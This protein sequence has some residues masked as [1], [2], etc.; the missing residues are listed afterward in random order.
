MRNRNLWCAL[1]FFALTV[2]LTA[3][4]PDRTRAEQLLDRATAHIDEGEYDAAIAPAQEAAKLFS[5]LG[6]TNN[7]TAALNEA[8]LAQ[9]YAGDYPAARSSFD[10][11]LRVATSSNNAEGI[12]EEH[13]NLSS[14]DFYTGRYA[15]A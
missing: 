11:A 6:D 1:F 2:S 15:D 10:E 7:H 9:L 8:G 14:V 12:V 4:P 5:T 13:M 3:A